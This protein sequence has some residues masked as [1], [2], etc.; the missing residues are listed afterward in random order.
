MTKVITNIPI[1]ITGGLR[2][3]FK[4]CRKQGL[5]CF[6]FLDHSTVI[7]NGGIRCG[8]DKDV[9]LCNML[10][11]RIYIYIYIGRMIIIYNKYIYI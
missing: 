3:H 9:D 1:M 7:M 5:V 2:E 10:Y 11:S 4:I 6:G 8:T